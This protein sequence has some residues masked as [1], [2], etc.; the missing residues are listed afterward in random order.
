[1]TASQTKRIAAPE[2]AGAA[3]DAG[4]P[5]PDADHDGIVG[6]QDRC[7]NEAET[8]NG[9]DDADGCPD[10]EPL[11]RLDG[12]RLLL[13]E[14]LRF[15]GTAVDK[16]SMPALQAV[17]SLLARLPWPRVA[18]A[19]H[20]DDRE[21]GSKGLRTTQARADAVVKVLATYS[22]DASRLDGRGYGDSRSLCVEMAAL[23]RAKPKDA[24]AI[25]ACRAAN[26]RVEFVHL[27][28]TPPATAP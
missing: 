5:N 24:A 21:S 12:D 18:I 2:V 15:R 3:A 11:V 28:P 14:P 23:L 7:P 25:A 9:K 6:E 27:L 20:G 17:A 10:G 4:C 8:W 26:A 1:M 13:T 19:V 16:A 22:V